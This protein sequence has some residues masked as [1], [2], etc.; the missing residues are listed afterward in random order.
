M[1]PMKLRLPPIA[2]LLGRLVRR[3]DRLLVASLSA[4]TALLAVVSLLLGPGGFGLPAASASLILFEIRL[5]RT[6]LCILIGAS[7]GLAG[8]A[9]QGYLRNPLAEPGIIGASSG[10]GVGAVLAIHT[11]LTQTLAL[12]LPVG[13]MLGA[14]AATALVVLLA[15]ERGGPLTLILAGV[16]VS[17]VATALL[18]LVLS[19]AQNPFAAVEIVFWLLGSLADRSL[20]HVALAG[21]FMVAGIALLAGLGRSLDALSL[22]EEAAENLGVDLAR[23]R[24]QAVI[25]A[26]LAVGSATAIAGTIGFVGLV[27]PHLL[28]PFVGEE[29]SRLLTVSLLGGAT[30]LLAADIAVRLLTP[31]GEL[32]LGV[33]T[34]LIGTP[35]FLW[36]IVKARR[37]LTT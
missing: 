17:S 34:A 27:V 36:L 6:L 16:A 13:G 11:G 30:L 7:L 32:R 33:L 26:A 28:R 10:A 1:N 20:V 19:L 31:A 15:G 25:G 18:S 22:G 9:L 3:E 4:A 29:P 14:L 24:L 37:E 8:A 21:P 5:P 12:A 35:L 23:L 2:A